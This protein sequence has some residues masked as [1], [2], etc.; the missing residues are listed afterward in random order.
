MDWTLESFRQYSNIV[1]RGNL[2]FAGLL[3]FFS[4]IWIETDQNTSNNQHGW[5]NILVIGDTTTAK[6]ETV[7]KL[8]SALN[9]GVLITAETASTVGLTGTATQ[10]EREGWFVDWGFLPLND[11]RLLAIDGAQKLSASQWASLA[12]SE[13]TGTVMITKAAKAN[14]YAR[15]RQIKLANPVDPENDRYSTKSI[16]EFLHP[17]QSIRTIL[18][19]TSIARLDLAVFADMRDV[20]AESINKVNQ[21][22]DATD[23]ELFSCFSEVIKWVWS[24]SAKI[25]FDQSTWK[26]LLEEA[27]A[28][29]D[30]FFTDSIPLVSIDM[31]WKLARLSAA[32][33][34][35]TIS[36]EDLKVVTVTADHVTLISQFLRS[37]YTKAGLNVLAKSQ[38]YEVLTI[39]EINETKVRLQNAT[40]IDLPKIN[41]ILKYITEEGRI[42]KAQIQ[43]KFSLAEKNELRP[44]M[45]VLQTEGLI[46]QGSGY[47]ATPKLIQ[48]YKTETATIATIASPKR[49]PPS[50]FSNH[51]DEGGSSSNHGKQGKHGNIPP[52]IL[53]KV[54]T[55]SYNH[56]APGGEGWMVHADLRCLL[57]PIEYEILRRS[58]LLETKDDA[59]LV[60][61]KT[62]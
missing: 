38:R 58:D 26:T 49:D 28:L 32:L 42:T 45:A 47:Y 52:E 40:Q 16:S 5:T 11:R 4:T 50:S 25:Q 34:N 39:E 18:D 41:A 59:T 56:P 43:S 13:R 7:R 23:L 17:V 46:K 44:L 2:A 20:K 27:T 57:S 62:Q 51:T 30:A 1:G 24:G 54:G 35:L 55:W 29:Y 19:K 3:G 21:K 15:T 37:E 10:T 36:T 6:S 9:A 14:A 22:V 12:E 48:L 53:A 60:R 8:I 31:K 61:L 33:A